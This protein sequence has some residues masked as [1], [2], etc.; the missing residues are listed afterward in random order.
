MGRRT[1]KTKFTYTSG[2]WTETEKTEFIYSGWNLI[3]EKS[4]QKEKYYVWG[5]DLSQ[6]IE[7][8]GG[9]GGLLAFIDKANSK[10][11]AYTFDGNGNVGQLVDIDTGDLA[12]SYRY[13]PFGRL[14]AVDGVV[15][16]DN[17]FRFSTKYFDGESGLYYYGYRY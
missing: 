10:R 14:I 4:S 5:L 15:D 6:S 1:E 9:V 8:A 16:D 17:P 11:Y 2:S 12:G 3:K 13:D 7:G